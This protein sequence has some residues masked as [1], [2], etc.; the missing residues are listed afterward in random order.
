MTTGPRTPL[1][2]TARH[3]KIIAILEHNQVRS[4]TEIA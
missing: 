4:Q 1:T 3:A 2:K